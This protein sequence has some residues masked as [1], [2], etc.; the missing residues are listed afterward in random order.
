MDNI[1]YVRASDL[2]IPV[3]VD[4]SLDILDTQYSLDALFDLQPAK[5][6]KFDGVLLELIMDLGSQMRVDMFG[7][8]NSNLDAGMPCTLQMNNTNSWG[9]PTVNTTITMGSDFP[10]GHKASPWKDFTTISGYSTSG[11]RY[12]RLLTGTN[13]V[14]IQIGELMI[15]KQLRTFTQW[16]QFGGTRGTELKWLENLETEYGLQRVHRRKI[17]Q[18]TFAYTIKGSD[19]DFEDLENLAIDVSGVARPFFVAR[20]SSIFADGG[21]M[22]RF[23]PES[24]KKIEAQEEWYDD[25]PFTFTVRELSRGIPL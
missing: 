3:V 18:R 25:N 17:Q 23:T 5:P 9:A 8:P 24:V 7:I 10:N 22:C 12:I 15:G 21:L 13:S 1:K 20:D 19:Q 14:N 6:A 16:A 2:I 11:F 4:S